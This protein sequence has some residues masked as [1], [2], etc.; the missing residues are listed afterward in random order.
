MILL[1]TGLKKLVYGP[2]LPPLG[3]YVCV[4]S[5]LCVLYV[6]VYSTFVCAVRLRVRYVCV[7]STFVYMLYIWVYSTF[8]CA[9]RVYY[10]LVYT[11]S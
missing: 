1:L 6:C 8:V 7:Y 4:Y 5:M 3:L 9:I 2:V 11:I 10:K